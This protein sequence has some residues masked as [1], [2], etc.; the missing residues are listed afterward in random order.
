[1]VYYSTTI[2]IM[3]MYC[4]NPDEKG[5]VYSVLRTTKIIMIVYSVNPDEKGGVYYVLQ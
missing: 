2:I 1:M 5:E 4:M 3:I